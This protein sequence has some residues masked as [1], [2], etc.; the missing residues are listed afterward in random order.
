MKRYKLFF[1][2]DNYIKPFKAWYFPDTD[3]LLK[4]SD[5]KDHRDYV[6]N[7]KKAIEQGAV[8]ISVTIFLDK[9]SIHVETDKLPSNSEYLKIIK[10]LKKEVGSLKAN[11][12]WYASDGENIF[13]V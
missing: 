6:P 2:E 5:K 11:I 7:T 4:F 12:Y 1:T 13:K 3:K 9:F 10:I 8:R